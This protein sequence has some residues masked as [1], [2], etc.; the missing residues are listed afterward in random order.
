MIKSKK[1][2]ALGAA[3]I[4]AFLVAGASSVSAQSTTLVATTISP[5][6]NLWSLAGERFAENV[7]ERT[8]GEVEIRWSYSGDLG[9][10]RETIEQLQF[11]TVDIV[12]QQIDQLSRYDDIASLGAYPYLIRDI[13]HFRA[14]FDE[15]DVGD[16]FFDEV[17]ERTGY[18]LIG[19]GFRG[20]RQTASARAFTNPEELEGLSIR[21]PEMDI[22]VDT[23]EALGASPTPMPSLEV[24]TALQQGIIEAAENPLEAHVRSRYYEAVPYI[25]ETAH[26]NPFYSWIFWG[27]RFDSLPEDVQQI[28]REEGEEAMQWGTEQTLEMIDG[29]R[30]Q[31]EGEGAEFIQPDLASLREKLEPLTE[32]YAE[33]ADWIERFQ[34]AGN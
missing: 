22:Y 34:S 7:A 14:I 31:L 6:D 32:K 17:E 13:D 25:V 15:T 1:I 33:Y 30:E 10:A 11:G 21:V 27:E 20:P 8:N 26:V 24:Y 9:G 28:L 4:A 18:R 12:V 2:Y 23:W 3:S 16:E 5:P 29:Y 19:A